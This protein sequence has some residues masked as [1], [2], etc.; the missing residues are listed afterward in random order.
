MPISFTACAHF[1]A[2]IALRTYS[3]YAVSEEVQGLRRE[4]D[5]GPQEGLFTFRRYNLKLNS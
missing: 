2:H 3:Y 5:V 1:G 4:L